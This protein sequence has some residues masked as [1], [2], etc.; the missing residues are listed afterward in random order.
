LFSRS[1]NI[2]FEQPGSTGARTGEPLWGIS[3]QY[4]PE[5]APVKE[6]LDMAFVQTRY[7]RVRHL[8]T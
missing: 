4:A 7:N 2:D 8:I 5:K 1:A 3:N 6:L